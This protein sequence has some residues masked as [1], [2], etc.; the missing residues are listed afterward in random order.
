MEIILYSII[1]FLVSFTI[2]IAFIIIMHSRKKKTNKTIDVE[3]EYKMNIKLVIKIIIAI[4]I[5]IIISVITFYALGIAVI[6]L[7]RQGH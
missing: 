2:Q 4:I 1:A 7:L 5:S 6:G 3:E